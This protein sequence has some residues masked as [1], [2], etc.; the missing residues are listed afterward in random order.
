MSRIELSKVY[1]EFPVYGHRSFRK[2]LVAKCGGG[3]FGMVADDDTETVIIRALNDIN[4]TLETG[5]RLGLIGHNGAGKTTMLKVMAGV[6]PPAMGKVHIEGRVSPMFSTGLGMDPEDSGYE[7]INTMGLYLGMAPWEI[8][9]RLPEI[10]AFCELGEFLNLPVRTYSSG[11]MVR[12]SF[13]VVTCIEPEILLL[14]EGLGAGDARFAEKA[15]RRVDRL[16]ESSSI[17]ALA[18][19]STGMIRSMC[20]KAILLDHGRI[21][22]HGDVENVIATYDEMNRQALAAEA[23]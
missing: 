19:H 1:I 15:K 9:E 3:I 14:D 4:L 17:L 10:E 12:L 13:A 6:L 8:R 20:N 23:R 7:N 16:I 2:A 5:D 18:S 22:Q 21:V 11:M